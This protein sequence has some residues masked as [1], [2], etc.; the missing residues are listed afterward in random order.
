[1]GLSTQWAVDCADGR[2]AKL[3]GKKV[4]VLI[5]DSP[6]ATINPFKPTRVE[7]ITE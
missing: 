6:S 1:V 5:G 2:S 7:E 3:D 4:P